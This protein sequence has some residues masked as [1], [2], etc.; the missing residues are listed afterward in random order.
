MPA[1]TNRPTPPSHTV[2]RPKPNSFSGRSSRESSRSLGISGSAGSAAACLR[3]R[4]QGR[5]PCPADCS[6]WWQHRLCRPSAGREPIPALSGSVCMPPPAGC[7]QLWAC[8]AP[9]HAALRAQDIRAAVSLSALLQGS[10]TMAHTPLWL[11]VW[12]HAEAGKQAQLD[13]LRAEGGQLGP[14]RL[15]GGLQAGLA[16]HLGELVPLTDFRNKDWPWLPQ[17][18][19]A[20]ARCRCTTRPMTRRTRWSTR[21]ASWPAASRACP[22]RPARRWATSPTPR[23]AA[24]AAS[25]AP[26]RLVCQASGL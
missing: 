3:C 12:S 18:G 2:L 10:L 20:E 25:G 23:G 15:C 14:A 4:G 8:S 21:R 1:K 17:P 13:A 16:K 5:L 26:Q 24:L 9:E 6:G 7:R 19:A 22:G 11:L